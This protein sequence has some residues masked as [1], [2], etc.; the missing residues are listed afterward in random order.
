MKNTL[1]KNK[2]ITLIALVVTIV[3]LLI[4]AGVSIN[5]ILDDN[6]IIEKSKEAKLE[7]RA[8]QVEDEIGLWK[9]NNFIRSETGESAESI[10]TVLQ[11]LLS[12]NLLNEDE[13]DKEN[14]TITIKRKDGSILKEIVYGKLRIKISKNP[15]TEKAGSVLLTV[16]SVQGL[17]EIE[18]DEQLDNFISSLGNEQDNKTKKDIIKN[19]MALWVNKRD[20]SANC[21]TFQEALKWLKEKGELE[22]DSEDY[23]W[24]SLEKNDINIDDYLAAILTLLCSNQTTKSL[25][26][27]T[28]INPDNQISDKYMATENGTYTFKVQD[29][30]TEKVYSKSIEVTNV[31][32]NML[33]YTVTTRI[34]NGPNYFYLYDIKENKDLIFEK[35]FILRDNEKIEITSI[36][37]KDNNEITRI[38][39]WK[40]A[41]LLL[42]TGYIEHWY[43]LEYAEQVI[44]LEK[45]NEE[46]R[47]VVNMGEFPS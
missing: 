1:R 7:T 40:I 32:K 9:Q 39:A 24:N 47:S 11:K 31:D 35:A 23:F 25:Y 44:I 22:E 16:E 41:K 37:E 43:S 27:A 21:T 42:E 29:M 46:Y 5:L 12:K 15:E 28:I 13:I 20:S 19:S 10:D 3:V 17:T 26:L 4:L 18:G 45:D 33:P 34:D 36:I 38:K 8:S 2:A 14:E 6:G 30:V